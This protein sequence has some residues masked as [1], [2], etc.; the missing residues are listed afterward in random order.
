[1]VYHILGYLTG[2][3]M[4]GDLTAL[5][6]VL[7]L[8]LGQRK[9]RR[10]RTIAADINTLKADIAHKKHDLDA[11]RAQNYA[12]QLEW[13]ANVAILSASIHSVV[14]KSKFFGKTSVPRASPI[15]EKVSD[16]PIYSIVSCGKKYSM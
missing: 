16:H 14:N 4:S 3:N 8:G 9:L 12:D 2:R 11:K 1:M 13:E 10:C 7:G 15:A 5:S 6:G